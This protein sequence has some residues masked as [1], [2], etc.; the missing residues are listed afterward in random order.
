MACG[1]NR[2]PGRCEVPPSNGAP[3]ITMSALDQ[4]DGSARSALGTPRNVA[5]GPYMLPS[6]LIVLFYPALRLQARRGVVASRT[7]RHEILRERAAG[8]RRKLDADSRIV[9]PDPPRRSAAAH[10]AVRS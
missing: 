1:P 6:R 8:K 9:R 7:Y 5:S 10:R 2:A 3:M 4:D